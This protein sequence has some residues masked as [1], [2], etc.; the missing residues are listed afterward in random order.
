MSV[1]AVLYSVRLNLSRLFLWENLKMGKRIKDATFIEAAELYKNGASVS[2][3]SKKLDVSEPT[4]RKY[5]RKLGIFSKLGEWDP[6]LRDQAVKLH[7]KGLSNVQISTRMFVPRH[8]IR[9]L[10]KR[11]GLTPNKSYHVYTKE[12]CFQLASSYSHI[13]PFQNSHR[14]AYR[15]AARKGW[16]E[17][18]CAHM[19]AMY[20]NHTY[21]DCKLAASK[22]SYPIDFKTNNC[23]EY[24]K[25]WREG[26]L[27]SIC[28][29]MISAQ[30]GC[31]KLGFIEDCDRNN[32]G[33]GVLYLIKCYDEGE[34]FYK[35]GITSLTVQLRCRYLI[36]LGYAYDLMWEVEAEAGFVWDLERYYKTEIIGFKYQPEL[37]RTQSR[38]TFICGNNCKILKDPSLQSATIV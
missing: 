33:Y 8:L 11:L 36:G 26:W 37:W 2:T 30:G 20:A 38:E 1:S 13:T 10:I 4:I 32:Q 15:Q 25:A 28:G 23:S 12:E 18:I 27:D 22:W 9:S 21:E 7:T 17:E 29:H 5:L 24:Q 3:I 19:N 14:N 35:I 34:S 6:S 31:S 16:L